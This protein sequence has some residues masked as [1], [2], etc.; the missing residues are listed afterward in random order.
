MSSSFGFEP[1]PT[2][3]QHTQFHL[4]RLRFRRGEEGGRRKKQERREKKGGKE[5][6]R[7]KREEGE[8]REGG[9]EGRRQ[10]EEMKEGGRREG[11]EKRE[12]GRGEGKEA[13]EG[14]EEERRRG[15]EEREEAPVTK[16][17]PFGVIC[18]QRT[19]S[20]CIVSISD[21]TISR[22][23]NQNSQDFVLSVVLPLPESAAQILRL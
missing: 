13:R 23:R 11:E 18:P 4:K 1:S 19:S 6:R 9:K 14:R 2:P 3:L 16:A 12:G 7:K 21:R 15:R 17:R 22:K 20:L 8:K 10:G 5:R